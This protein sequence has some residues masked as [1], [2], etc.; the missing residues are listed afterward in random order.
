MMTRKDNLSVT[1]VGCLIYLGALGSN[2]RS[3][4]G[5]VQVPLP[6]TVAVWFSRLDSYR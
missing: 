4:G 1:G 5:V 2:E 6:C 3:F